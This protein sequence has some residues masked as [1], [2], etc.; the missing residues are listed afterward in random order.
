[1]KEYTYAYMVNPETPD[2]VQEYINN[3]ARNGWLL[4][5]H[6]VVGGQHSSEFLV[7]TNT[8]SYSTSDVVEKN[9]FW[10]EKHYFVF[11]REI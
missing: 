7:D 1:M 4:H 8:P 3:I 6:S 11:E 9:S 10:I 5:S 2:E